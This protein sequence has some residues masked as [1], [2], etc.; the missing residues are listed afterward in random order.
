MQEFDRDY[1]QQ[2]W[3]HREDSEQEKITP[4]NPYVVDAVEQLAPGRALDA[5]CGTGTESLLAASRGWQVTGADLSA[6]ALAVARSRAA[7]A[8]LAGSITFVEAD[9][10]TWEP[11]EGHDLVF[12]CY[13]HPTTSHAEFYARLAGW[14]NPGGTLLIVGHLHV[15]DDSEVEI[16]A[17]AQVTLDEMISALKEDSWRIDTTKQNTRQIPTPAGE[18]PL[19]D[20]VLQATRLS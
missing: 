16:P 3:E 2:H 10:T 9:L 14:V 4:P 8:D 11:A 18:K 13:A 5:G 15:H 20:V 17:Q 12:S 1:W 7:G 6:N 19:H